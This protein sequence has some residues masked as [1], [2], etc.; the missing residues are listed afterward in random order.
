MGFLGDFFLE[1][2]Y[3]ETETGRYR[4]RDNLCYMVNSR[5]AWTL[6]VKQC[7]KA[8]LGVSEMATS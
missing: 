5:L 3:L 7:L 2:Q 4:S 8:K 6:R 1:S